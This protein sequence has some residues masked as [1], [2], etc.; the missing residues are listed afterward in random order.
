MRL[1]IL[2]SS[3]CVGLRYGHLKKLLRGF[4]RQFGVGKFGS[5]KATY[6]AVLEVNELPDLPGR[7][8][9]LAAAAHPDVCMPILLRLPIVH[10]ASQVVQEC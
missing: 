5:P 3:T 2:S 4:S 6:P 9:Y 7:S 8:L 10:N 1:R